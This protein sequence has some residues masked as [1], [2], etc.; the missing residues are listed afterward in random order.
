MLGQSETEEELRDLQ[1][2]LATIK[3][4]Q[5]LM[6]KEGDQRIRCCSWH[7]S[8]KRNRGWET[9]RDWSEKEDLQEEVKWH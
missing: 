5:T 2:Q 8:I 3:G 7:N 9:A 6:G 4:P 1:S